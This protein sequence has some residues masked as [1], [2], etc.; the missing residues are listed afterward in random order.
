[1]EVSGVL[2]LGAKL[3]PETGFVSQVRLM[4]AAIRAD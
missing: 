4:A 2:D 3:D 1:V